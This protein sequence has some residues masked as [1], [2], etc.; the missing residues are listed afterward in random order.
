MPDPR[1][2]ESLLLVILL[3]CAGVGVLLVVGIFFLKTLQNVLSKVAPANRDI[4]PGLVWLNLIPGFIMVWGFFTV[5]WI[6]RSMG[7]EYRDRGNRTRRK[8]LGLASA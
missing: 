8:V 5:V 4:A 6:S 1:L 2:E 7:K 3:T